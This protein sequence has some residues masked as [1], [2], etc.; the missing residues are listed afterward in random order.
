MYS[1]G[2]EWLSCVGDLSRL[3]AAGKDLVSHKRSDGHCLKLVFVFWFSVIFFS[4]NVFVLFFNCCFYD[5]VVHDFVLEES[6][7]FCTW[8]I[9]L[10]PA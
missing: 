8:K 10:A 2:C 1:S 4:G 6:S 9:L 7:R 5:D 3:S